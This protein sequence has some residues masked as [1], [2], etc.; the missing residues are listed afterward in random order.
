MGSCERV[1]FFGTGTIV[2]YISLDSMPHYAECAPLV[3][4][5]G[6]SL[7]DLKIIPQK[8]MV[9]I[10]AVIASKDPSKDIGVSDCA[11]VHHVLQVRLQAILGTEDTSMELESPG[12]DRNIRNA[13][14]FIFFT[15]RQI[16]IWDKT[17]NDWVNGKIVAADKKS[18]TLEMEQGETKT[19]AYENIAK[20]KFIH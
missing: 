5:L 8:N 12:I 18:V 19:I 10:S 1:F 11:K 20:A 15:G 9:H 7:V 16:R 4:G 13:A 17:V 2:D 6:Y 14:E 3:E